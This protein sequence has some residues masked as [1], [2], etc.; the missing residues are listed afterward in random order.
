MVDLPTVPGRASSAFPPQVPRPA[1]N[2]CSAAAAVGP[3]AAAPTARQSQSP[4][5]YVLRGDAVRAAGEVTSRFQAWFA[6]PMG[7]EAKASGHRRVLELRAA[8][9]QVPPHDA[10]PVKA[11]APCTSSAF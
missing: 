4:K 6:S 1:E 10:D 8:W 7:Q 2:A 3:G 9:K 5:P 11:V